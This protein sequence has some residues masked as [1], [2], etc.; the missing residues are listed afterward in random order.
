[1]IDYNAGGNGDLDAITSAGAPVA[2]DPASGILTLIPGTY[3][4]P[5]G[6]D[7]SPT[8]SMTTV[9]SAHLAWSAPFA[10]TITVETC[11]FPGGSD[12]KAT[13][14]DDVLD[15]ENAGTGNW[16]QENPSTAYV[17][18]VGTNNVVISLTITA[19]G[20]NA[21]GCMIDIGNFGSRRVRLKAVVTVAGTLRV[22]RR[23]KNAA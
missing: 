2:R 19:G 8:P 9:V 15:Y 22:N 23:G 1:M 18:I 16:I 5:I 17:G 10:A 13:G 7:Q 6:S 20:T 3:F 14:K 21:G 4:L 11:N 12:R